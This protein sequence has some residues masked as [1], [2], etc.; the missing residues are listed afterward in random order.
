MTRHPKLEILL[1]VCICSVSMS[2]QKT[3]SEA[4]SSFSATTR[5]ILVPTIVTDK[6]GAPM[7]G[8][9][10]EDFTLNQD[11]K[12]QPITVFEEVTTDARR[13][14]RLVGEK[15]E[16]SNIDV[17][18]EGHHRLAIIVLDSINTPLTNQFVGRSALVK[19]LEQ[20]ADSGEPICL[21]SLSRGGVRVIH[22]FTED[23]KILAEAVRQL[24]ANNSSLTHESV[25]DEAQPLRTGDPAGDQVA[26]EVRKL[27][28]AQLE[29]EK[30]LAAIERKNSAI[31]TVEGLTQVAK[32]FRGLPGRKSLIWASA[33]FP[34]S[35]SS[36]AQL[37][38]EPA[39]PTQQRGEVQPLYDKLWRTMNDSQM[40]IYAVDL[41][42]LVPNNFDASS[43]SSTMTHGYDV[44][45][46]GFDRAS[47]AKWQVNDSTTTLQLFA[48]NTGGKAFFNSNDL[49]RGFH[50]A[51][52]DDSHY[53]IVGYYVD[54]KKSKPGWHKLSVAVGDKN[55]RTRSRNG[56]FLGS[57]SDPHEDMHLA[58]TSPLDFPGIPLRVSWSGAQVEAAAGKKKVQFD[59]VMPQNFA[60]IDDADQNHVAVEIAAVV[61]NR[62]GD[63]VAELSQKVDRRLSTEALQQIRDHGMTYRASFQLPPGEYIARFAVVDALGN[64][65][66]SV[67]AP[68][69]VGP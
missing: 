46:P 29:S 56:F 49:I 43:P 16:F 18:E 51:V 25:I 67:S 2:S 66:G 6:A 45:V 50:E 62:N 57:D 47:E 40:S 1:M 9:K 36:P 15:G 31:V 12:S 42:S 58:L 33:G 27:I 24:P 10:K 3:D 4:R 19:F 68:V 61:R 32:I 11:G 5:L 17:V 64:R 20:V 53:Y 41:R 28:Q 35:L 60:V 69:K 7:K 26:D 14:R 38:C 23:P 59:L 13:Y 44:G 55:A 65:A 21:L 34:Y 22:D 39:C 63:V 37:M 30:A 54:S 8:L 48:T 52:D